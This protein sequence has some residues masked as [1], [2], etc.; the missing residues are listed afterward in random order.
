DLSFAGYNLYPLSGKSGRDVNNEWRKDAFV[1]RAEQFGVPQKR[2]RVFIL[3]VRNDIKRKPI[4]LVPSSK[5]VPLEI[6]IEI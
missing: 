4:P 2:H 6:A 3:G 5:E 1:I